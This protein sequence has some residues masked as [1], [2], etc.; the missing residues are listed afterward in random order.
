[1][2]HSAIK[3]TNL[4]CYNDE[5]TLRRWEYVQVEHK[6]VGLMSIT[7]KVDLES[8]NRNFELDLF[9]NLVSKVLNNIRAAC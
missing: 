5:I 6:V 4:S 7:G 3:G 8:L 9:D 2:P 1:M